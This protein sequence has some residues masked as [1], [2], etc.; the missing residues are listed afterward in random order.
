MAPQRLKAWVLSHLS[1]Y[2]E[3]IR[4]PL[5]S[6]VGVVPL[7]WY[8]PVRQS[9]RDSLDPSLKREVFRSHTGYTSKMHY[10]DPIPSEPSQKQL[11]V[12]ETTHY[13]LDI[14]QPAEGKEQAPDHLRE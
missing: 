7:L 10:S 12:S 13:C 2:L 9:L 3:R 6:M 11:T 8:C 4:L 14:R 5:L 1:S